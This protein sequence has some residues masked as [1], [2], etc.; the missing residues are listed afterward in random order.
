VLFEAILADSVCIN[1]GLS[2]CYT[3]NFVPMSQ[4]NRDRPLVRCD[5]SGVLVYL[6]VM[7]LLSSVQLKT[8]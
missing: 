8:V 6:Q 2:E 1:V 4:L 5:E 3:C 7:Q